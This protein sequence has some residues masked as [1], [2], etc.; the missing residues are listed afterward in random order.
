VN[1]QPYNKSTSRQ[2]SLVHEQVIALVWDVACTDMNWHEYFT[3]DPETGNLIWKERPTSC[4]RFDWCA[5]R[6][7][8]RYSGKIS[9][10]RA[11]PNGRKS[12]YRKVSV[13]DKNYL[14]HRIIWEMH[15]GPI[16]HKAIIDHVN[17]DSIDNRIQNLRVATNSQN[18]KNSKIP[19]RNTSGYKGV[20]R[21][22]GSSKWF[23]SIRING[24]SRRI[25]GFSDPQSAHEVYKKMAA[26]FHGEFA[27]F[28]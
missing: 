6:W 22:K 27:R 16:P 12:R 1:T 20:S 19:K 21:R 9:G 26:E 23:V 15:H 3:Y 2:G 18:S 7:N 25:T 4:F 28:E 24:I 17:G 10:E 5:K 11:V 14:I 8:S 13:N